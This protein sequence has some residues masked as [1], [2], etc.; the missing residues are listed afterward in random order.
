MA[1]RSFRSGQTPVLVATDKGSSSEVCLLRGKRQRL[2]GV[3]PAGA[4]W[5]KLN[6]GQHVLCRVLYPPPVFA[7]LVAAVGDLPAE[8]RIGL[9]TDAYRL[10]QAGHLPVEQVASLLQGFQTEANDKVWGALSIVLEGL[11]LGFSRGRPAAEGALSLG[12][13]S[14]V[15]CAR[16][17]VATTADHQT[18][19]CRRTTAASAAGPLHRTIPAGHRRPAAG[20]TWTTAEQLQTT[21]GQP[22]WGGGIRP[23]VWPC[24]VQWLVHGGPRWSGGLSA[25]VLHAP[26]TAAAPTIAIA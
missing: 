25:V 15:W 11:N 24:S 14:V 21:D 7:R 19:G 17:T 5:L 2:P 22:C 6:A 18:P 10:A 12:Q 1:L 26:Q 13:H 23:G 3:V 8:D 4:S 9:V 20:R 16:T